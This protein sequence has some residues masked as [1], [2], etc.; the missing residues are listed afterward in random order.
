LHLRLPLPL[1]LFYVH[2]FVFRIPLKIHGKR[3]AGD[4]ARGISSHV[5]HRSSAQLTWLSRCA[6]DLSQPL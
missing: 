5:F 2:P 6:R 1:S 3:D 4:I